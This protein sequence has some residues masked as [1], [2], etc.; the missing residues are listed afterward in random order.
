MEVT[1]GR[2]AALSPSDVDAVAL[3]LADIEGRVGH[4]VVDEHRWR[5]M[6]AGD[7]SAVAGLVA[8]AVNGDPIAYAQVTRLRAGEWEVDLA[9]HPMHRAGPLTA[10]LAEA[11]LGVV[12]AEGGGHVQAWI[13][14]PSEDDDAAMADLGLP[15]RRDLLQLR[16]ELPADPPP[17][18]FE[19]RAFDA[20][21]DGD[22]WLALNNELFAW[23]PEQGG[24]TRDDLDARLG[25]P[26]FDAAGF[27]LHDGPDGI[28]GFCWTKVHPGDVGEIYVI[29]GRPGLGR[30]LVLAGL[31]HLH[32][33]RGCTLGMLYCDASNERAMA[34][35][36]G[37]GFAV[38]HVN[39]SY[40]GTITP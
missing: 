21:A 38:G 11:A 33:D 36:E 35:Y 20:A 39:R 28:D 31:H 25:A 15:E 14:S 2:V 1:V 5:C 18:G 30:P 24:W 17:D 29:A 12:R 16:R 9:V 19:V 3:L 7:R 40:G 32:A 4:P 27:L 37:L 13:S 6:V 26:W 10:G 8:R 23:H 22:A 34:L